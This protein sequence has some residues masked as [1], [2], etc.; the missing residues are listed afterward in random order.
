M[1]DNTKKNR[2]SAA[3]SFIA[4][5]VGQV[6]SF[7]F[8]IF[9]GR[10]LGAEV[11][12]EYIYIFSFLSICSILPKFGFNSS[13]MAFLP[14]ENISQAEKKGLLSYV[15]VIT[16][17]VSMALAVL[18]WINIDYVSAQILNDGQFRDLLFIMMMLLPLFSLNVVL[19]G[20]M[21]GTGKAAKSA[22]MR[23]IY[24]PAIKL[25]A[26]AVLIFI[27]KVSP[28]TSIVIA[29]YI[30]QGTRF[31][32]YMVDLY[33]RD[34]IGKII[35]SKYRMDIIKYS[36]PL[37]L[38]GAVS[39]L[40]TNIDKYFIGY[41]LT[42]DQVAIYRVAVQFSNV[43]AVGLMSI[44]AVY[45]PVIAQLFYS[46]NIESIRN[47]YTKTTKWIV[48]F[49]LMIMGFVIVFS[50]DIMA[51]AGEEFRVGGMALILVCLGQLVNSATGIVGRLNS[52]TRY[53]HAELY[54]TLASLVMN[55]V[56][57]LLL[58]KPFGINGVAIATMMSLAT[59]NIINYIFMYKRFHFIP[60]NKSY[61]RIFIIMGVSMASAFGI[62]KFINIYYLY[63]LIICG[64][65]Y[66]AVF[67][68]LSYKY[69]MNISRIFTDKLIEK[70]KG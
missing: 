11:Y 62:S 40:L 22:A 53:Q 25:A 36:L 21:K 32:Y 17:S 6:V 45:S 59:K 16:F 26:I 49:N 64:V 41:F 29:T 60:Y 31:I 2:R 3:L 13:L 12:G 37:F 19:E 5:I 58:I 18:F 44:R 42:T 7:G 33:R 15:L 66:C 51:V 39:I 50:G 10:I 55:V 9:A 56:C 34:Y 70:Q 57:N 24:V 61:L 54:A 14:R 20:A 30:A 63:E 52:M 1:A 65:L 8:V 69:V 47:I 27:L 68:A 28:L 67:I 43:S 46:D 23:L 48:L 35:K 38:T 4:N